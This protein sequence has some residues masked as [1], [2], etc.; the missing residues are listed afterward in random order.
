MRVGI[1]TFQ[2]ADN[3]GAV[4]QAHALQ[5]FLEGRGHTVEIIDYRR[6]AYS[7]L[8]RRWI[9]KW[10]AGCIRKWEINWKGFLF[11][12]F[13][14]KYL[15]LT[16]EKFS[17]V[18]ELQSIA[19][20]YELLIAGSDQV[21]NP[22]WLDQIEGLWDLYFLTFAGEKTKRISY[23]ASIGHADSSTLTGEWKQQLA[24]GITAMDAISVRE[25]SSVPLVEALC[26]RKDAVCVVDPT[27]LLERAHYDRFAGAKGDDRPSYLFSFMLH[28][29]EQDA[30]GIIQAATGE[31]NLEIV[32]CNAEK[33]G[34]HAGYTLP[35]PK[36]WLRR[37]R[38][39]GFVV[40]NSFHCTVFC[41][42]FHVP[43]VTV[44]ID[45]AVGSMNSRIVDLL[46]TVGLPDR[47][48]IVDDDIS[49][50]I[51]S[52]RIEWNVVDE[53]VIALRAGSVEFLE[54]QGL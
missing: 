38:D 31:L 9:S 12:R 41:L 37:I 29:L 22:R 36:G 33:T 8:L 28:G 51:L 49:E 45:G 53:Q 19:D 32:R 11:N 26:G 50:E 5:T 2:W 24:A 40:T 14:K 35:S 25:K 23:A 6:V 1:V 27:L 21:W 43:F 16:S 34:L 42:I 48:L 18:S 30:E 15:D 4:L 47:I 10:P 13:R 52:G 39:A 44:L 46:S 3:Y 7:S 54:K 20:R 17:S